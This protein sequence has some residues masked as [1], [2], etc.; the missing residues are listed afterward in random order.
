MFVEIMGSDTSVAKVTWLCITVA[1]VTS[2]AMVT[3]PG[4][5]QSDT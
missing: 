3:S 1:R 2:V 5:A 4:T